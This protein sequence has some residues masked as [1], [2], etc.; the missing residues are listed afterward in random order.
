MKN[1]NI[2]SAPSN[3]GLGKFAGRPVGGNQM[4]I[5][6]IMEAHKARKR[7]QKIET[8]AEGVMLGSMREDM[9]QTN[10]KVKLR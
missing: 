1:K 6:T 10:G 8:I 2:K 4:G 3:N 9:M 7:M 5:T